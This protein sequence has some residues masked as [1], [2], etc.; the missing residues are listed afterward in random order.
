MNNKIKV[1]ILLSSFN[2]SQY[3][4]ECINGILLQNI[5]FNYEIIVADDYSNDNTLQMI[6]ERFEESK[7]NFKILKSVKNIGFKENYKRGYQACN[8]EYIAIIEGDDY[9]TDPNRLIKHIEF[10]DS[11][12]ECV[13]SY[14]RF[15]RFNQDTYRY[16][17]Q[18]WNFNEDFQYITA[19]KLAEANIIGNL[20]ACVIR[21]STLKKI[22]PKIYEI[23]FADWL[24]AMALGEFGVICQLKNVMSVYRIHS[25]GLWSKKDTEDI[26]KSMINLINEYDS[27][28]NYRYTPEFIKNTK[29]FTNQP[30]NKKQAAYSF[31]NEFL[32]PI[33][34]LLLKWVTPEY[35][36]KKLFRST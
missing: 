26:N 33:L 20:S 28:L 14:N 25:N 2:Q 17:I 31:I 10:L 27:F 22:D 30:P 7:V 8:G 13:L 16:T 34:L 36:K 29:R 3:I 35:F 15:I 11:H 12:H 6:I 5:P 19:H 18:D 9:W 21:N 4:N 32:P 1:S 24:L 23:G